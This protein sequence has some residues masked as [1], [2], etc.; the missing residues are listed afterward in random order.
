MER[1]EQ[2]SQTSGHGV[3]AAEVPKLF[4]NALKIWLSFQV[5]LCG[6]MSWI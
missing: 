6:V 2:A 1:V 3:E 4:R 5:A